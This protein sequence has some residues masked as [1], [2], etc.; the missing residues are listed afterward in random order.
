MTE[1]TTTVGERGAPLARL[2]IALIVA[3]TGFCV[4][5]AGFM[6]DNTLMSV[7]GMIASGFGSTTVNGLANVADRWRRCRD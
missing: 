1:A 7:T 3:L 5:I 2:G 4:A 6:I